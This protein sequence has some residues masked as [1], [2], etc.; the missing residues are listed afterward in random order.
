MKKTIIA[1]ACTC[2]I[3]I[4]LYGCGQKAQTPT[5][6]NS[7]SP[8][9]SANPQLTGLDGINYSY[10]KLPDATVNYLKTKSDYKDLYTDKKFAIY[11]VGADCPYAQAFIDNIEPLKDNSEIAEKYNFYPEEATGMKTY[12][13]QEDAKAAIDFSNKCQEFCIVNPNT[14]EIFTIDGIGNKEAAKLSS[15]FEQLKNW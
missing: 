3:S 9:A 15:I 5:Q 7:A 13:S 12:D 4:G 14:N 2:L 6:T 1:I 10:K 11:Y 8:S